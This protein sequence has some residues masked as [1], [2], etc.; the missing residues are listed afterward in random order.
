MELDEQDN[1]LLDRTTTIMEAEMALTRIL[2][3]VDPWLK[4]ADVNPHHRRVRPIP[5]T[6]EEAKTILS[7]ARNLSNRTSAPA[8]WNPGAPI[9]NFAT[10][11][12]LPNQLR[13]GALAALQPVSYTHLTLPTICSV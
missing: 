4:A 1:G 5:S 9:T 8:G 11:N 13:G 6:M 7:V 3:K 12:P 2:E 10:P